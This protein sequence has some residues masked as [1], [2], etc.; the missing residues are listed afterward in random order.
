MRPRVSVTVLAWCLLTLQRARAESNATVASTEQASEPPEVTVQG[1]ENE[2][3]SRDPTIAGSRIARAELVRPGASAAA[4]LSHVPGVQIAETGAGSEL[5]S[6]S[7]RGASSAQTPVYL[8]GIRLN[9]DVSGGADLSLVPLWMLE[10]VEV[11]RGNAPA[12]A[13]RL[14]IGGA[15]FFEPRLPR[16]TRLGA[17]AGVGSFGER[18][19]FV[20]GEVAKGRSGAL[21]ALRGAG[22]QNDYP[23]LDDRGTRGTSDDRVVRRPNADYTSRDAWAIARSELAPGGARV[24][25]VFNAFEREQGV[26]GLGATPARSARAHSQRVL[27][28]LSAKTPCSGGGRCELE[29]KS[30][31][32]SA[33]YSISDPNGELGLLTTRVDSRGT[34][35]GQGA[36]LTL[37]ADGLS[38]ALGAD[39]ELERLALDSAA[40]QSGYI[41]SLRAERRSASARVALIG[42]LTSSLTLSALVVESCDQT[43]SARASDGCASLAP[44][45]RAGALLELGA[46]E[47]RGNLG[48]YVRVPTLGELYGVSEVV[49]GNQA[50]GLERGNGADLGAR[51][52]EDW[53]ATRHALELFVFGREVADLIA[54]RRSSL[55]SAQPYNVGSARLLGAELDLH[56]ELFHHARSQLALSLLD[57]RDTT[58]GRTTN[59]DILPYRSRLV[60]SEYVEGF[61]ERTG[62]LRRAA[63]DA[64]LSYRAARVADP[65]GLIVLPASTTLDLGGSLSLGDEL[66][67]LR[68][69][70]DDVLDARHFDLIGYP[71][72]GRSAHLSAELWW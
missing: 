18:N 70:V 7:L 52:T 20:A 60:L 33:A 13:E 61:V 41:G 30:Q 44:E 59:N 71:L 69:A 32:L 21:V 48:H 67:T 10:R 45:A 34:R 53:G 5:A 40:S 63:L 66:L 64:R 9:D 29:L 8:A 6:A 16:K 65:A 72:P 50:L 3:P 24:V 68:V 4:V 11:Y 26:S 1:Q 28:G 36:R 38:V 2:R 35:F 39:A 51:V 56:N 19:G 22:A 14:G 23:Y 37:V 46:L 43:W 62:T 58:A 55:G 27:A 25:T 15:V 49:R 47:L 31:G 42:D 17:G 12:D 57:P 54:Y